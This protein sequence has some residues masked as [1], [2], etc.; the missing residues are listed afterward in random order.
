M[1]ATA[2]EAMV[3]T[4]EAM[5]RDLDPAT[6]TSAAAVELVELAARGEKLAARARR[7]PPGGW[8]PP[9]SGGAR[10]SAPPPTGWPDAAVPR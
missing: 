2:V 7:W 3:T 4:L 1:A 10:V 8:P 6:L 5:V 9:T